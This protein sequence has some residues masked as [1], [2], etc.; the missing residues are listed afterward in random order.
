M[1]RVLRSSL[2]LLL[3]LLLALPTL[4]FGEGRVINLIADPEAEYSLDPEAPLLEVIFPNIYSTD[5]CIISFFSETNSVSCSSRCLRDFERF[6]ISEIDDT[7]FSWIQEKICGARNDF[8]PM[9]SISSF[10]SSIVIALI[11]GKL[12]FV[13]ILQ[14]RNRPFPHLEN[15]VFA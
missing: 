5:S 15:I 14:E 7:P 2:C 6:V 4:A 10:S 3:A 1:K 9:S 11:S 13:P 8:S 12:I